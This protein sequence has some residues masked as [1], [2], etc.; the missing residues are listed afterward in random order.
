MGYVKQ[1]NI[2]HT[3]QVNNEAT[4]S[5]T[6]PRAREKQNPQNQLLE[7][8]DGKRL[9][10]ISAGETIPVNTTVEDAGAVHR[11][12]DTAGKA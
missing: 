5:D 2:A 12:E 6:A 4:A 7:K 11:P 8:D 3:Q 9:E 10:S 1:A